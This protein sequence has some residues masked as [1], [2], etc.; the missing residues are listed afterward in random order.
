[1]PTTLSLPF[2][3]A[4]CAAVSTRINDGQWPQWARGTLD[5]A[6]LPEVKPALSFM[7]PMQRR[8]LSLPA[9]LMFQA[10]SEVLP[11]QH[12]CPVV[13]MSHDGEMARSFELWLGL[14]RDKEVS[15]TSFG[16]S[17]H[18]A[19]A[20]QF[21]MWRGDMSEY[22]ALSASRDGLEAA[23]TEACTLLA[24]GAPQVLVLCVDEPLPAEYGVAPIE[25]PPF[26]YAL[27]LLLEAGG[28][29]ELSMRPAEAADAQAEGEGGAYSP[30]AWLGHYHRGETAWTR[31]AGGRLWHWRRT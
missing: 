18:N 14:L 5:A 7:P 2:R 4:A 27:A 28:G 11:Q 21:S 29:W 12:P 6:A 3:I 23:V 1:M 19:L 30:L 10:A 26:A 8:R 25:R 16:L 9:R 24:D 20:G 22:T 17:V 15:P 31:R 13:F